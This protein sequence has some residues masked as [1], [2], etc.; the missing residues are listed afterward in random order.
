[1]YVGKLIWLICFLIGKTFFFYLS[2]ILEHL[3]VEL[4]L[5]ECPSATTLYIPYTK[6]EFWLVAWWLLFSGNPWQVYLWCCFLVFEQLVQMTTFCQLY[7]PWLNSIQIHCALCCSCAVCSCWKK[8]PEPSKWVIVHGTTLSDLFDWSAQN[9]GE[10]KTKQ[11]IF[12][13]FS[14]GSLFLFFCSDT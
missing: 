9:Y 7:S 4:Y 6:W 13:V 14:F 12:V 3:M 1:M 11:N 2:V 8:R 10:K 5:R